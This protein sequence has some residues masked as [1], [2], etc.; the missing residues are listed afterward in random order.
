[1]VVIIQP[2]GRWELDVKVK[3]LEPDFK[4]PDNIKIVAE[5][6]EGSVTITG[7][8]QKPT[9]MAGMVS[10]PYSPPLS[11]PVSG[12]VRFGGNGTSGK[13]KFKVVVNDPRW[14]VVSEKTVDVAYDQVTELEIEA[15]IKVFLKLSYKD[16]ED[17]ERIIPQTFPATVDYKGDTQREAVG[18]DGKL[19]FLADSTKPNFTLAFNTSNKLIAASPASSPPQTPDRLENDSNLDDLYKKQYRFFKLPAAWTLKTSDWTVNPATNYD[20]GQ[21]RFNMPPFGTDIGAAGNEVKLVL[22]PHWM[23]TRFEF[24]DRYFGP[25]AASHKGKRISLP[26]IKLM[27]FRND[28]GGVSPPASA[29]AFSNWTIGADAQNMVQCLPWIQ[30]RN[31]GGAALPVLDA[32]MLLRFDTD[33]AKKTFVYSKTAAVREIQD[34]SSTVPDDMK[35]L[36]PGPERLKYYDLPKKWLSK[37]YYTRGLAASPPGDAKF[38]D[39]L[40]SGEI[41][42]AYDRTKPLIFSLDDLILTKDDLSQITL[43][44]T[45][46]LAIVHHAFA[47]TRNGG[48]PP[49]IIPDLSSEGIY[50]ASSGEAEVDEEG[51]PYSKVTL[52]RRYYV[53]DYP[54]WTR[55]VIAQGNLFDVFDER[56]T[57]NDVVGARAAVRWVD[58]TTPPYG[59]PAGQALARQGVVLKPS[60]DEKATFAFQPFYWQRYL[61]SYGGGSPELGP[62]YHN[63]WTTK[64]GSENDQIG[65]LDIALF[66]CSDHRNGQ[67]IAKLLRFNRLRFDFTGGPLVAPSPPMTP[68][69]WVDQMITNVTKRWNGKDAC[70]RDACWIVPRP[71][72]PPDASPPI[73]IHTRNLFQYLKKD[74]AHFE[75]KTLDPAGRSSIGE[76]NGTGQLRVNC[77]VQD[78]G[79]YAPADVWGAALTGRGMAAA[80]EMGHCGSLPDD[81]VNNNYANL[82]LLGAPYVQ[83]SEDFNTVTKAAPRGKALMQ[84]NWWIRARYFWHAAEWL[85]LLPALKTVDMKIEHGTE[86]DFYIPHYPHD[87]PPAT[88]RL[89]NFINWP[90]TFSIRR[91]VAAGALFDATLWL[92]GKD[93]YVTDILPGKR[94]APVGSPPPSPPGTGVVDG[95]MV[96]MLRVQL[97]FTNAPGNKYRKYW[98]MFKPLETRL[99]ALLEP[100][101]NFQRCANFQV[102]AGARAQPCFS[103]CLIH[104]MPCLAET[105]I[106][107]GWDVN[108]GNATPHLRVNVSSVAGADLWSPNLSPPGTTKVLTLKLDTTFGSPLAAVTW[109]VNTAGNLAQTAAKTNIINALATKI[110][111][112]CLA[113]LGLSHLDAAVNSYK[114]YPPYKDIVKA[115][116]DAG[117]PEPQ[118][119]GF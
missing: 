77:T 100:A 98:D 67:E 89:R 96:V 70:N 27:G 26:A 69:A 8:V 55:L 82:C 110:Y 7:A 59:K 36:A 108:I 18:A 2:C 107:P 48:S 118:I 31:A 44:G 15:G 115:G 24:F 11:P 87:S 63:E 12:V 95:I 34:L 49:K 106:D 51:Y 114:K 113:T 94:V 99:N 16:P 22:D 76:W 112:K 71:T 75:L 40:S 35:K 25:D 73:R 66:R 46:R 9:M 85:R 20:S 23:Y 72:S 92:L 84:G 58:A 91:G 13:I 65:R 57:A 45:Q 78:D 39:T 83:E 4:P 88:S 79:A 60:A 80:H 74:W 116:I 28:P 64:Y 53:T 42:N 119:F 97:D 5:V 103:K 93:K 6:A 30:Q 104:F 19:Y 54:D 105:G 41:S 50:K 14:R 56:T 117:A 86:N 68:K 10:P 37:K 21:Y 33:N 102:K 3:S 81:Y 111:E 62:K 43:G 1:M 17:N 38:F 47:N 32:N 101:L 52:D 90:V 109:A 29:D 61:T